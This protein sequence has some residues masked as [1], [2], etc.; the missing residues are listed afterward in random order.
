ML[1]E[2]LRLDYRNLSALLSDTPTLS[3]AIGLEKVPHFTTFQKACDRLLGSRRAKQLLK[4][5][6]DGAVQHKL[7]K[8]RVKLAAID[9]TGFRKSAREY[10]LRQAKEANH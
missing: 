2:F 9:G 5:T 4:E 1:K 10:L 7:M 6:V 3:G 8:G